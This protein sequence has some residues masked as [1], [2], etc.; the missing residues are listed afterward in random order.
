MAFDAFYITVFKSLRFHL[1]T[2]ETKRFQKS[3][4][5]KLFLQVSVF[6]SV[7][8]ADDRRKRIKKYS[9]LFENAYFLMRFL[10]RVNGALSLGG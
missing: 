1:S 7:L 4:L 9:F 10:I 8:G 5:L 3:P 6:I 2:P